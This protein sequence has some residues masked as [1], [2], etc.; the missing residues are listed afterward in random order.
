M[1]CRTH[2]FPSLECISSHLLSQ[3]D[4]DVFNCLDVMENSEFLKDLK[5]GIGDG[6]L[7]VGNDVG[8]VVV[9]TLV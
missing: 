7:Q 6:K 1:T 2:L 8:G 4:V 9:V 3:R 5:F